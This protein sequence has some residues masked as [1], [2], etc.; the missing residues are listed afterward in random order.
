MDHKSLI[1]PPLPSTTSAPSSVGRSVYSSR[2]PPHFENPVPKAPP[3]SN[4][5][6]LEDELNALI[7]PSKNEHSPKSTRSPSVQQVLQERGLAK[8]VDKL[9]YELRESVTSILQMAF[10]AAENVQKD[11][12]FSHHEV[13]VLRSD[14]NKK[15]HEIQTMEKACDIYKNQIHVLEESVESLQDT[16]DSRKKFTNRNRS[17]MSRLATTNRMLIDAL[18][19]LQNPAAANIMGRSA[20]PPAP[21]APLEVPRVGPLT[22]ITGGPRTPK[23]INHQEYEEKVQKLTMSQN[24]KLRESL[25]EIAREHYKSLKNSEH[26]ETKVNEL[27]IALKSQEQLNRN[28]KSELDEI[29][30]ITQ[31]DT[32]MTVEDKPILEAATFVNFKAKNFSSIDDRFQVSHYMFSLL[33]L[34]LFGNF[35]FL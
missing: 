34:L 32:T 18:D 31:V 14:L 21:A 13:S 17:A 3:K 28:L 23:G 35:D 33:L 8:L 2:I 30:A 10:A 1:R 6:K 7:T 16:I 29:K 22:P 27:K 9:P 26:L 5:K 11:L 12:E 15:I 19:A 24:D 20:L 25:L 4:K